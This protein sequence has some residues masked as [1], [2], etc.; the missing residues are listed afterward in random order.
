MDWLGWNHWMGNHE[1]RFRSQPSFPF[2]TLRRCGHVTSHPSPLGNQHE[3]HA[4]LSSLRKLQATCLDMLG[5][6]WCLPILRTVSRVGEVSHGC[7]YQ[8]IIVSYF[9]NIRT[10]GGDDNIQIFSHKHGLV[11]FSPA[12]VNVTLAEGWVC[13]CFIF[14]AGLVFFGKFRGISFDLERKNV[15]SPRGLC[16]MVSVK[17]LSFKSFVSS[18]S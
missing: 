7:T 11:V 8:V 18:E 10:L 14:F 17:R 4:C 16:V 3:T 13:N 9:V 15:K 12:D 2:S 6:E 5:N 1:S